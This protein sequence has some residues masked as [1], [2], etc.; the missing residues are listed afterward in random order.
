MLPTTHLFQ[1]QDLTAAAQ[2]SVAHGG[3][4]EIVAQEDRSLALFVWRRSP[5]FDKMLADLAAGRIVPDPAAVERERK[6]LRARAVF[7][8]AAK[9][10]PE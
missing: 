3:P 2:I 5:Q 10:R 1:S 9:G 7:A 8:V 6:Q 4:D